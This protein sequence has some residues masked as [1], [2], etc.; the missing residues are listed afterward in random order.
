MLF[1][2]LQDADK[3]HRRHCPKEE[4]RMC[5]RFTLRTPVDELLE[6][7]QLTLPDFGVEPRY[8]IAPTQG[9][10]TAV[11]DG[12]QRHPVL[13][14]WGLIPHWSKDASNAARMINARQ[15]TLTERI[16]YKNLVNRRRCLI[17]ADGF[18]EWKAG[19]GAKTP[20]YITLPDGEPFAM[21]G[22]WDTWRNP[23]TNELITSCTIV[24]R[25]ACPSLAEIHHRMPLVLSRDDEELW[26]NLTPLSASYIEAIS[27]RVPQEFNY[28]PVSKLVNS[29][30]NDSPECILRH[31]E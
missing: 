13:M 23:E 31:S 1:E 22:L 17:L 21:A 4:V 28:Y 11:S 18:Y 16:S 3:G 7:F 25:T 20:M 12:E 30:R 19:N 10:L 26:V 9:I 2:G 14:R 5:G 29:P 24:T 6:R 27:Q 8:N 15:E